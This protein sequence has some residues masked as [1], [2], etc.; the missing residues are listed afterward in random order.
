MS[1]INKFAM[2]PSLWML[3]LQT[4]AAQNSA[5]WVIPVLVS[6]FCRTALQCIPLLIFGSQSFVVASADHNDLLL[7]SCKVLASKI[8]LQKGM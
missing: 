8:S 2:V 3:L 5:F 4:M 1:F 6:L 7:F